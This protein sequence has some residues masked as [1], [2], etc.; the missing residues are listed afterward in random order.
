MSLSIYPKSDDEFD[1]DDDGIYVSVYAC[2]VEGDNDDNLKFPFKGR[3]VV[4]L[5]NQL[6]D[7]NHQSEELWRPQDAVERVG[8]PAP[9][10][11]GSNGRGS[12]WFMDHKDLGYNS[13]NKCQYLKNN[14]LFFRIDKFESIY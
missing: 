13:V 10:E 7:Q 14:C 2:L 4:S 9:P 5:L 8:G 12:F 1:T 11:G 3:V 6:E